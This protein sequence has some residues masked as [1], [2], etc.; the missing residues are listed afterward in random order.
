MKHIIR[1]KEQIQEVLLSLL[2][3]AQEEYSY[4]EWGDHV[5]ELLR[6][7]V[8]GG[9]MYRG[10]LLVFTYEML[11]NSQVSQDH[12]IYTLAAALEL[13]ASTLLV[14][15]DIMDGD[16][17][18]RGK[19]TLH[20]QIEDDYAGSTSS[21]KARFGTGMA[22]MCATIGQFLVQ[23]IITELDFSQ[24]TKVQLFHAMST[25]S[26]PTG[27]AQM[28]DVATSM[29][30]DALTKSEILGVYTYK[31]AYYTMCLPF[32]LATTAAQK[33]T[34]P[35][36]NILQDLGSSLGVL[37]QIS[38][39]AISLFSTSAQAGKT[40][41][42]DVVEGKQTLYYWYTADLLSG[43]AKERFLSLYGHAQSESEVAE[44]IAL[45][46]QSGARSRVEADTQRSVDMCAHQLAQLP[47][48]ERWKEELRSFMQ[49]IVHRKR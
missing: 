7:F 31:T 46:E 28:K 36:H 15:D 40:R 14:Q 35:A 29:N 30:K 27:L 39:D 42:N 13:Y 1:H 34:H 25:L 45:I 2:E 43:K 26:I 41:G 22:M 23:K 16:S 9:K 32:A 24:E 17:L 12:P 48:A 4:L 10:S 38:D 18:R 33:D 19:A 20:V 6:N 21:Q 49:V 44:T 11:H 47:V 37:Y 3:Q 8:V 5:F